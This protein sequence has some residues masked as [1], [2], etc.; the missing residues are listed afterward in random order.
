MH[1]NQGMHTPLD[2]LMHRRKLYGSKVMAS[3]GSKRSPGT[4]RQERQQRQQENINRKNEKS[5][6]TSSKNAE[7][8]LEQASNGIAH[9]A[10]RSQSN[11]SKTLYLSPADNIEG[12]PNDAFRKAAT[13]AITPSPSRRHRAMSGAEGPQGGPLLGSPPSSAGSEASP[14]ASGD[15]ADNNDA[16]GSADAAPA[17]SLTPSQLPMKKRR[18]MLRE[19]SAGVD[20]TA[21]GTANAGNDKSTLTPGSNSSGKNQDT[22]PSSLSSPNDN[23]F[24]LSPSGMMTPGGSD[25]LLGGGGSGRRSFTFGASPLSGG[26]YRKALVGPY[27]NNDGHNNGNAESSPFPYID[28]GSPHDASPQ[29]GSPP[30]DHQEAVALMAT[31]TTRPQW[32]HLI[33]RCQAHPMRRG[34][35]MP[36]SIINT[37]MLLQDQVVIHHRTILTIQAL[38]QLPILRV[39]A[40]QVQAILHQA[41]I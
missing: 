40:I 1:N 19:T 25:M 24:N 2:E 15:S 34:T 31:C 35:P 12:S 41:P 16:N 39:V 21:E 37:T 22:S 5:F 27:L 29:D 20:G 6:A 8:Q 30:Q 26:S 33:W 14:A 11:N 17:G 7:K 23:L 3:A 13:A 9:T 4:S 10:Q 36:T 38:I 28:W 18:K 32:F